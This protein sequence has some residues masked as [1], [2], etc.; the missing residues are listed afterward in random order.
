[1]T[2]KFFKK[3]THIPNVGA[4]HA[5]ETCVN[6]TRLHSL[7]PQKRQSPRSRLFGATSRIT[8]EEILNESLKGRA[9]STSRKGEVPRSLKPA[10]YLKRSEVVSFSS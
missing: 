4:A 5:S 1:M 9:K 10:G 2:K 7:T 6:S 8:Y 3:L